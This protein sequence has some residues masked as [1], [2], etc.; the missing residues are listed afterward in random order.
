MKK[1]MTRKELR[2]EIRRLLITSEG[3]VSN[4]QIAKSLNCS[5][6][7]VA[8]VRAEL[9]ENG[10]LTT[11]KPT[12]SDWTK[13]PYLKDNPNIIENL[14]PRVVRA[15]KADGVLDVMQEHNLKSSVYAQ[16]MI[17]IENKQKRKK[18]TWIKP[19][20][21]DCLLVAEDIR[22]G[23][24]VVADSSVDLVLVDPPYGRDYVELYKPLGELI[25]RTLKQNGN[26]LIMCGQQ[27]LDEKLSALCES[28]KYHWTIS[29]VT[30]QSSPVQQFLGVRPS[31]KVIL[32]LRRKDAPVY[33]GDIHN[34][35]VYAPRTTSDEVDKTHHKWEQSVDGFSM[36]VNDFSNVGD[37]VF[38]PCCGSSTTGLAALKNARRYVG[39]D[40]DEKSIASSK[41]RIEEY[42]L[43]V[44]DAENV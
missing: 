25:A 44:E 41:E 9:L 11:L 23:V 27:A 7:T 14:T 17:N 35:V 42:I 18:A 38:D 32:W 21:A 16:Q 40:I 19:N 8:T 5:H 1:Q 28:L 34:D 24:S 39:V 20:I 29:Y 26:A 3:L 12:T 2:L 33:K 15:L 10:E 30:S 4:R 31:H 6:V 36:L 37:L 22:K 43:S 13:H